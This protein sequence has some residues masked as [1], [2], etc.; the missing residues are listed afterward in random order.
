MSEFRN[1]QEWP[2]HFYFSTFLAITNKILPPNVF[3]TISTYINYISRSS[4]RLTH[5]DEPLICPIRVSIEHILLHCNQNSCPRSLHFGAA[6]SLDSILGDDPQLL[7][8]LIQF[9]TT[10]FRSDLSLPCNMIG[11]MNPF[12]Y[13]LCK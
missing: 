9:L 10:T 12:G 3:V 8:P 1:F 2:D 5:G 6:P 7:N 11:I 4:P 13:K